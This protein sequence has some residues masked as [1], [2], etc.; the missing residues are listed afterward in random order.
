MVTSEADVRPRRIGVFGGMFDPPHVGHLILASEAAWQLD[1]DEVRLVVCARPPHRA[2]GWLDPELR[3]RL[4]ECAAS[5]YPK[6]VA[7]RAELDRDGS[8]YTV[9]TLEQFAGEDPDVSWWLIVGA[10]QLAAFDRWR[11]PARI[12]ELARLAVAAR[13]GVDRVELQVVADGAAPD[14]VDWIQMPAVEVSSSM[15]RDRMAAGTPIRH[16]VSSPVDDLLAA[17]S[18][19]KRSGTLR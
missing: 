7:S 19:S 15:I 11:E 1:L 12:V 3:F 9:D 8:S 16:L 14:R 5:S 10:D 13:S 4:V 18:L 2:P 17:E 6:L